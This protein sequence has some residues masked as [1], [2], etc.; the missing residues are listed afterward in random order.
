M[1]PLRG[2]S[3]DVKLWDGYPEVTGSSPPGV[4]G[5]FTRLVT[6]G[7]RGISRG[8]HKLAWTSMVIKK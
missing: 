4:I 8:V 6:P 1:V 3:Y 5:G 7:P 2:S